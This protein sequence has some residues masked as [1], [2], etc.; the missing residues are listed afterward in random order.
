MKLK[1]LKDDRSEIKRIINEMPFQHTGEMKRAQFASTF[2]SD[3]SLE[4]N[5]K[6]LGFIEVESDMVELH[7]LKETDK[8]IGTIKQN[9]PAPD[10]EP[11]NRVIF[12]L[13]FKNKHTL[14]KIPKN[15]NQN[16]IIQVDKVSIDKDFEGYGIASFAYSQLVKTGFIVLSDTSQFTDG[17]KLWEKMAKKAHLNSYEIYILDDEYGFKE[18]DG[19]TI[20]YNG[21]NVNADEIWS[22]GEDYSKEHILLMMK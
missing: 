11:S 3:G 21:T 8:V 15:I 17:R 10:N 13:R 6:M 2:T 4:R 9:K 12:S 16:K 18:K 5:Y 20:M 22:S 19:K 7:I 1:E 14:V